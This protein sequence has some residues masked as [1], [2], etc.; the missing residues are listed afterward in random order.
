MSADKVNVTVDNAQTT[1]KKARRG[2][3]NQTKAVAQ[4]RFHE[5]DASTQNGL[6]IGHLENVY[7]DWA[8]NAEG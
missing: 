5:K 3:N 1:V 4:L 7:V 2:V 6:F 8:V